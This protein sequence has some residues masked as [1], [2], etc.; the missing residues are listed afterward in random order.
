MVGGFFIIGKENDLDKVEVTAIKGH[1]YD[2]KWRETGDSYLARKRFLPVLVGMGRVRIGGSLPS[3]PASQAVDVSQPL[4][5]ELDKESLRAEYKRLYGKNAAGRMSE[6]G[7][8]EA[9]DSFK[10]GENEA[11]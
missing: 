8:R 2:N 5:N 1:T 9:I 11:E 7:L 6:E 3:L 10:A 4:K